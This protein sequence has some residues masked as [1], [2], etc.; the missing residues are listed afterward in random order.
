ME[1]EFVVGIGLS[2]KGI[3]SGIAETSR[4]SPSSLSEERPTLCKR[5]KG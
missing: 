3:N 1:G 4:L 2:A 5:R